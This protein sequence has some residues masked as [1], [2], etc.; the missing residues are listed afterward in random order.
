MHSTNY[1]NCLITVADDCKKDHGTIPREKLTIANYHFKQITTQPLVLNS[2]D[3][4]FNTYATR[5]NIAESDLEDERIRFFSTGQACLRTSPLAKS[6]GWGIYFNETGKVK[7]VD[8]ASEEYN[9]L[10]KDISVK[11]IPAMRNKKILP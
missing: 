8:S 1:F 6:Y 2:D 3:I 5:M 10:I 11:K 9:L 4:I 7:L